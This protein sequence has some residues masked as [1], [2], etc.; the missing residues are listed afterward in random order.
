M[1][2]VRP[3]GPCQAGPPLWRALGRSHW[4]QMVDLVRGRHCFA[5]VLPAGNPMPSALGSEG[6]PDAADEACSRGLGGVQ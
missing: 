4:V 3:W 6:V 5:W 2:W 1:G